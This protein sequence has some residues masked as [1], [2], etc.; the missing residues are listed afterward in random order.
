[1]DPD[2]FFHPDSRSVRQI[3]VMAEERKPQQKV[4]HCKPVYCV[5]QH[6]DNVTQK[7]KVTKMEDSGGVLLRTE[8]GNAYNA[9]VQHASLGFGRIDV[10]AWEDDRKKFQ[11]WN[12]RPLVQ[13]EVNKLLT[14]F[15]PGVFGLRPTNAF[16]VIVSQAQLGNYEPVKDGLNK[17]DSIPLLSPETIQGPLRFASGQHRMVALD[18]YRQELLHHV[19][20]LRNP[21][22]PKTKK[23]WQSKKTE[24]GRNDG[25]GEATEALTVPKDVARKINEDMN[26][27]SSIGMWLVQLFDEGEFF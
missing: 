4:S 15:K 8:M 14:S 25:D 7:I 9:I 11:L 12:P 27:L 23:Q 20:Y 18:L 19:E 16:P 2:V 26:L 13:R 5:R 3:D 6:A 24:E 22:Q 1:M 21:P 10:F 17:P